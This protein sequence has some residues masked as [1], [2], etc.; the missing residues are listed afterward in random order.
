M[1]KTDCSKKAF[2]KKSDLTIGTIFVIKNSFQLA[3]D[4]PFGKLMSLL[5][6]A[7]SSFVTIRKYELSKLNVN[8]M[9]GF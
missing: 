5:F 9:L 8:N 2:S 1:F 6:S 3:Y 7:L 4:Y